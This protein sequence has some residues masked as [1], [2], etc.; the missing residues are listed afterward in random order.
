MTSN[1]LRL[2][3]LSVC[4]QASF[5]QAQDAEAASRAQR[6][7]SNPL[8]MI[9]EASK[10]KPRQ[11]AAEPDVAA[12]AAP[13][14]IAARP[15]TA[16]PGVPSAGLPVAP[17]SLPDRAAPMA[18]AVG[19]DPVRPA[20]LS[21][22]EPPASP[23]AGAAEAGAAAQRTAVAVLESPAL[24]TS[25][26]AP[27]QTLPSTLPAAAIA[28]A[29][30][31]PPPATAAS[32]SPA[33]ATQVALAAPLPPRAEPVNPTGPAAAARLP[34]QLAD[35]VEPVLPDRLRRRLQGEA[36]VVVKFTVNPD[37]SVADVAVRSSSDRA[38]DTIA[39]DAVS[40]WRYKPIA[41][42]QPHAVELVF[43]TAN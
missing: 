41:T 17:A 24:A 29:A 6:D 9:I 38:L 27:E 20:A 33:A 40:Q 32:A 39:L 4:L 7:A 3:C 21:P 42:A 34:L 11:K 10:L 18:L 12:K 2:A 37:G 15:P 26:V 22:V 25:A 19:D 13:E 43:K 16:K 8:R 23:R 35:Y 14:K 5:A 1:S 31:P 28:T 36:A 30:V